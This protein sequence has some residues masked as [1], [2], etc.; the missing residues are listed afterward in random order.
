MLEREIIDKAS[1]A[2][3]G[4]DVDC[5]SAGFMPITTKLWQKEVAIKIAEEFDRTCPRCV[6]W[7]TIRFA[8]RPG[9]RR[10]VVCR[11]NFRAGTLA[12]TIKA[13]E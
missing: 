10:C 1:R 13:M 6:S 5:G 7:L 11:E 8:H 4:E 9:V 2:V 12:D 3:D